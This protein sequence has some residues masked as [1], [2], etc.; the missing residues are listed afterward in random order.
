MNEYDLVNRQENSAIWC[1]NP[2]AGHCE[3]KGLSG[4]NFKR[5]TADMPVILANISMWLHLRHWHIMCMSQMYTLNS[6]KNE[7]IA[8]FW[9][10]L[11]PHHK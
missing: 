8:A 6:Y 3:K 11:G 4:F 2:Q 5:F 10:V 9:S 7:C 1:M